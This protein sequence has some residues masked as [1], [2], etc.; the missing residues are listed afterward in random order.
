VQASLSKGISHSSWVRDVGQDE[1]ITKRGGS[2]R[3][4]L[5]KAR[6][7]YPPTLYFDTYAPEE[8]SSVLYRG[9]SEAA[10]GVRRRGGNGELQR[11]PTDA[12]GGAKEGEK[13][14]MRESAHFDKH[15]FG[16][17]ARSGRAEGLSY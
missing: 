5:K 2:G 13:P 10:E 1:G 4:V 17:R 11:K 14:N 3:L 15:L 12:K 7:M 9:W 6:K 16:S 8:T